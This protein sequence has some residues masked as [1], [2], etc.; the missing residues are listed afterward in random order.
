[1]DGN[2]CRSPFIVPAFRES[3]GIGDFTVLQPSQQVDRIKGVFPL[4]KEGNGI[5][6]QNP[7]AGSLSI[8]SGISFS[9]TVII[10][11]IPTTSTIIRKKNAVSNALARS[12]AG[13]E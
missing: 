8:P 13:R 9:L 6:A 5:Y 3:T 10:R 1:M 11:I 7:T 2:G 4:I 12:L